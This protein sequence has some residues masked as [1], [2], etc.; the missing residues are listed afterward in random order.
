MTETHVRSIH[1]LAQVIGSRSHLRVGICRRL[2]LFGLLLV[3]VVPLAPVVQAQIPGKSLL[4]PAAKPTPAQQA[5][6]PAVS[7]ATPVVQPIPL[8][9]VADR[10]EE[11]DHLVREISTQL[12]PMSDLLETDRAT[13][14]EEE[15]IRQRA[16]QVANLL[17][18]MPN[19]LDLQDEDRYWRSLSQQ[20]VA[21]RKLL[22]ASAANL[23][24]QIRL[25]DGQEVQWQA[26][27]DQI[28]QTEGIEAILGKHVDP[29]GLA[30]TDIGLDH[31]AAHGVG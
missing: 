8:P 24:D 17:A 13:K 1:R 18:G 12:T 3:S 9:Q 11:L 30:D 4:V 19:T 2:E 10:A 25:L 22:R 29:R 23:Q 20:Y 15:E 28:H 14:A 5:E 26:T 6:P 16:L 27:W 31:W 21:Q 7:P